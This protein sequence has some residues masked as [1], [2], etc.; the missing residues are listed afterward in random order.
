[1]TQT[2][3]EIME[4]HR[5]NSVPYVPDVDPELDDLQK[6]L[7]KFSDRLKSYIRDIDKINDMKDWRLEASSC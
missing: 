3:A 6:K 7:L 2:Y 5:K 1:M 4:R